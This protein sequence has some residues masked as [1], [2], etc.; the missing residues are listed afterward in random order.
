MTHVAHELFEEFPGHA[1]RIRALKESDGHFAR[2]VEDYHAANR[3]IHRYETRVEA[4]S[5]EHE[6]AVRRQRMLLKD[7]IARTLSQTV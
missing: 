7:E 1:A 6:H 3:A 2:L 4:V 5:E